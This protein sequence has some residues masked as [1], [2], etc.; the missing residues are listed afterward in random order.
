M[1]LRD[2]IK[3]KHD[4][5]ENHLFVKY[6]FSGKLKD[7][8][9]ATYLFNQYFIYSALEDVAEEQGLLEGIKHIKRADKILADVK[10]LKEQ[11]LHVC[12]TTLTYID[13]ITSNQRTK[14]D[15]MAHI[16][17]RHFGDMFGGSM[18]KKVTP[19]S[20]TMYEFED[21]SNLIQEVRSRLDDDMADE[22]KRVFGFAIN[23]FDE[24]ADVLHL[25]TT[26]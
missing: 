15:I 19:G 13:Y 16:Y 14:Q 20:G 7:R 1:S 22:A 6:L 3:E 8:Q 18:I 11:S 9:Y 4:E 12:P 5:A 10:E 21:R 24:L 2:L 25:P 17:V 23:L 26:S